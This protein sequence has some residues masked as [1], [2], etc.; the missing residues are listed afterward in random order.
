MVLSLLFRVSRQ[1]MT[2]QCRQ[3]SGTK[4]HII[5]TCMLELTGNKPQG[6]EQQ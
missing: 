6:T 5:H 4:I 3:K 2:T 1:M